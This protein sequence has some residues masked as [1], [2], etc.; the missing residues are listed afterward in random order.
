MWTKIA[1]YPSLG[2]F[3]SEMGDYEIQ[4]NMNRSDQKRN[5]GSKFPV[6]LKIRNLSIG[7]HQD[8]LHWSRA[9]HQWNRETEITSFVLHLHG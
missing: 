5:A 9:V 3:P 2:V 1:Y 4:A 7:N 8:V 6:V